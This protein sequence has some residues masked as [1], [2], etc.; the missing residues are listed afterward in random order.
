MNDGEN[1]QPLQSGLPHAPVYWLTVQ[2]HFNDLVISTYGRGFWILDDITPLRAVASG[3]PVADA[4]LF[5]PRP[6]YRFRDV[7]GSFA[8][9][10]DPAT[11]QNPHYG[12]AITY[13]L[14]QPA[15]DTLKDSVTIRIKDAGG[16]LVRTLKGPA[17]VGTQRLYWDL[18]Y[19]RT[20]E[21]RLRTTPLYA[22]WVNIG[23]EGKAAP[24]VGRYAILAPP[25]SYTVTLSHGGKDYTQQLVLRKDPSSGGSE[26][27]IRAQMTVAKVIQSDVDETVDMINTVEVVR[28]QLVALKNVLGADSTKKD[29]SAAADSLDKKLVGVE[30]NL[31]QMRTTG[32][33][34]DLIR[35]P[36]QLAEKLIYLAGSV[37]SS[38]HAPTSAQKEVQGLLHQRVIALKGMVDA[39][40]RRDVATFN[41]MLRGRNLQNIII[42][43]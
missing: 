4:H 13:W 15:A 30:E 2:E 5:A 27:D 16:A 35:W 37:G 40:L 10:Y 25:G 8:P 3:L 38:D 28:G 43:Q 24:G 34:Q 19:E 33:G 1:W 17:R 23:L 14:K 29:V 22:P 9:W 6:A 32:R 42:T 21:A 12:A 31:L 20:K 11:G 7:E 18:Q 41:E 36:S 39:L 26:D